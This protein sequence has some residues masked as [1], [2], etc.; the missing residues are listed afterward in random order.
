MSKCE[1][2]ETKQFE[3]YPWDVA[4]GLKVFQHD[5]HDDGYFANHLPPIKNGHDLKSPCTQDGF[6][7]TMWLVSCVPWTSQTTMRSII[8]LCCLK[9]FMY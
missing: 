2:F 9:Q 1:N 3:K 4:F 7:L 5:D 6:Y 8:A